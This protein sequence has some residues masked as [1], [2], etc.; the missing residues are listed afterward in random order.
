MHDAEGS[1]LDAHTSE[2]LSTKGLRPS[3]INSDEMDELIMRILAEV[4]RQLGQLEQAEQ[5]DVENASA[6]DK[7]ARILASLER[8][9]ERLAKV[10]AGR[11]AARKAKVTTNGLSGR[12][13]LEA[14]IDRILAAEFER[15]AAEGAGR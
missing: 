11:A 5:R 10:E 2:P 12:K 3:D 8:T 15:A 13:A 14:R 6:R 4:K 1:R 7:H 9:M